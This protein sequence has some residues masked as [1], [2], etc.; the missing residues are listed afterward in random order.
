MWQVRLGYIE[1]KSRPGPARNQIRNLRRPVGPWFM[2]T[3]Q[4]PL[5][6]FFFFAHDCH[7]HPR[8]LFDKK[9]AC[10]HFVL[11]QL[12]GGVPTSNRLVNFF[13]SAPP[14]LAKSFCRKLDLMPEALPLTLTPGPL[15]S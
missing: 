14:L 7:M 5:E 12:G 6:K 9:N 15:R 13:F 10:R 8:L 4:R 11:P 2:A 1:Y 3:H